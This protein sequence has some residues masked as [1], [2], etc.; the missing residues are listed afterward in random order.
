M[1][2]LFLQRKELDMI[3]ITE[4]LKIEEKEVRLSYIRSPG[5]GGQN[6]NKVATAVQL[7][8][9]VI[10]SPSLPEDVR[11]RLLKK[12]KRITENGVLIMRAHRFRSQEKNR[13][14]ILDRFKDS[15]RKATVPPKIRAKTRPTLSSKKRRL[16][17]KQLQ[18]RKKNLRKAV[19][20]NDE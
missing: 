6:V 11:A 4:F 17:K 12:E 2:I 13:Q 20:K 3:C 16:D 7:H 19:Y 8:F 14:D 9:D 18:S 10:N 5:P 1:H 15:I